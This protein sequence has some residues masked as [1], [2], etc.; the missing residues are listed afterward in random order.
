M[1]GQRIADQHI[2]NPAAAV[3][4]RH[5]NRAGRLFAHFADYL[6]ILAARGQAQGVEGSVRVFRRHHR[7]ELA[8]IRNVQRVQS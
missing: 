5:Q 2:H 4:R 7:E 6:G 1:R 3:A 8:F